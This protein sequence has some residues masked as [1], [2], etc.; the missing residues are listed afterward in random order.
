MQVL[1]LGTQLG[2]L[3]IPVG[4][5]AQIVSRVDGDNGVQANRD[6]NL[7]FAREMI[8]WRDMQVPLIMSSEMLGMA[9]GADNAFTRAVVVWPMKDTSKTNLFAL[10]SL[11]SPQVITLND[12]AVRAQF[13]P[14]PGMCQ[15]NQVNYALSY[16]QLENQIG[17]IPD[18]KKLSKDLF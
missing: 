9:E 1:S 16:A 2:S 10:S 12:D 14:S 11:N 5:V 18:L 3:I 6:G 8:G 4:M 17:I 15:N 7:S 13:V